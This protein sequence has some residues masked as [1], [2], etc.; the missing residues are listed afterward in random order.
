M[1]SNMHSTSCLIHIRYMLY[2]HAYLD[3]HAQICLYVL[4]IY[5]IHACLSRYACVSMHVCVDAGMYSFTPV[6]H[7]WRTQDPEHW[8]PLCRLSTNAPAPTLSLRAPD[9]KCPHQYPCSQGPGDVYF[10]A[11]PLPC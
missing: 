9:L 8:L 10:L 3:H 1:K 6:R 2:T 11:A 4:Y 5:F 7:I